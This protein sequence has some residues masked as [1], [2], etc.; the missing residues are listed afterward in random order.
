MSV[1]GI[2]MGTNGVPNI[3]SF[4]FDNGIPDKKEMTSAGVAADASSKGAGAPVV[5]NIYN[6]GPEAKKDEKKNDKGDKKQGFS[7]GRAFYVPFELVV[8]HEAISN[9]AERGVPD[10]SGV[11]LIG[12]VAGAAFTLYQTMKTK[13]CKKTGILERAENFAES[14]KITKCFITAMV[15]G[16]GYCSIPFARSKMN[17]LGLLPPVVYGASL[18]SDAALYIYNK[19]KS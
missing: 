17:S 9:S 3:Q 18:G 16:I 2:P 12:M 15:Y 11:F 10:Y 5:V 13:D 8:A 6:N 7:F 1:K 14:D 4:T 19:F